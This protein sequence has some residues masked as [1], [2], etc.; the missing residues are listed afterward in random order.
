[1]SQYRIVHIDSGQHPGGGQ[2]QV[3]RLVVELLSRGHSCRLI[4]PPTSPIPETLREFQTDVSVRPEECALRGSWD[5]GSAYRLLRIA[6]NA[7][8]IHTHDA[9]S[10][11]LVRLAH[12]LGLRTPLVVHR[13]VAF[14][15][16]RSLLLNWK[17]HTGVAS[18][19]A[20]SQAVGDA[21][22]A[23]GVPNDRIA[24]V[25]SCID[26]NRYRGDS[27]PLP[28]VPWPTDSPVVLSVGRLTEEKDHRT[29]IDAVAAL[30]QM[31]IRVSLV[32]VGDGPLR[33]ELEVYGQERLGP[34]RLI[35][36][37]QRNDV[38]ALL[39]A[40]SVFALSSISEGCPMALFEAMAAGLP[41]VGTACGGAEMLLVEGKT[42]RLVRPGDAQGMARALEAALTQPDETKRMADEAWRVTHR[43]LSPEAM[44]DGVLAVYGRVAEAYPCRS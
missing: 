31:G 35:M 16:R 8:L 2:R 44:V 22:L 33:A 28:D 13:R 27:A 6:R 41:A 25:P 1:M 29:S 3:A 40:A 17:Y 12:S 37:G 9:R 14:P 10:H 20:V 19:I 23:V 32:L 7:D 26:L 34:D 4:C 43:R 30:R 5:I 39:G 42:G 24:I 21:L 38:P 15:V 36:L 18:Y 11:S